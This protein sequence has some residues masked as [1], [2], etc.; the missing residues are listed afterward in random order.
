MSV[1]HST[2]STPSSLTRAALAAVLLLGTLSLAACGGAP[3]DV[4]PA[5][6]QEDTAQGTEVLDEA[7]A[8]ASSCL[9]LGAC[10]SNRTQCCSSTIKRNKSCSSTFS[11]CAPANTWV[12]SVTQCCSGRS[13]RADGHNN[14]LCS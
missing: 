12:R 1:T 6:A 14:S 11:C 9:A 3:E 13:I 7:A 5:A 10:A 4:S 2:R 8:S